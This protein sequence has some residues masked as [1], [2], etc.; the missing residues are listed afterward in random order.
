[1]EPQPGYCDPDD[2]WEGRN[3]ENVAVHAYMHYI[4]AVGGKTYDGKPIPEWHMIKGRQRNGWRAAVTGALRTWL[5][6]ELIR[7]VPISRK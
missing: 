2:V 6:T 1:M 7:A 3:K 5:E 4:D